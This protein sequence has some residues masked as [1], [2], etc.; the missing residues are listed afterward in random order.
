MVSN[1]TPMR[2][3][4]RALPQGPP[5]R[6]RRAVRAG[7]AQSVVRF[8]TLGAG[9]ISVP[10]VLDGLGADLFGV[11]LTIS[12]ISLVLGSADLGLG[13][14][15]VTAVAA[16]EGRQDHLLVARLVSSAWAGLIGLAVVTVAFGTTLALLVDWGAVLGVSSSLVDE[17]TLKAAILIVVG[18]IAFGIAMSIGARTQEGLQ[19][20]TAVAL[21]QAVGAAVQVGF[22]AA[23]WHWDLGLVAYC[24][25]AGSGALIAGVA[26][27]AALFLTRADIRPQRAWIDAK[28]LRQ[29][30]STGTVYFVLAVS[31][32]VAYQVDIVVIAN[33]LGSEVAASY[34]ITYRVMALAPLV[35]SFFLTPFW[36]AYAE[37]SAAGDAEWIRRIFRRTQQISLAT[38]VILGGM[39]FLLAPVIIEVWTDGAIEPPR[40][41]LLVLFIFSVEAGV[42]GPLAVLLNGLAHVRAQAALSACMAGLN[43]WLS[44]VLVDSLG[45]VGPPLVTVILQATIILIP[46]WIIASRRLRAIE[47]VV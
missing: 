34:G 41:L 14:G 33:H 2:P 13:N 21:W 29:L 23:C 39:L 18:T 30:M 15:L 38:S 1:Q 11:W 20:G 8:A 7:S 17:G 22:T 27:T 12:S 16:A 43:L 25:A 6:V 19:R 40:H 46:S 37:A 28:L 4:R 44:L 10:L 35:C 5:S 24:V 32:T 47:A 45:V 9:L 31:A 36:P 42:G 3:L 26:T